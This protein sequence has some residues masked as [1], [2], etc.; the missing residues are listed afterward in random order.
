MTSLERA[1]LAD[2]SRPLDQAFFSSS[3]GHTKSST[4]I[5]S[6]AGLP[7]PLNFL[8]LSENCGNGES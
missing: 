3:T 7:D 4:S 8:L 2:S 1:C 6:A 5:S